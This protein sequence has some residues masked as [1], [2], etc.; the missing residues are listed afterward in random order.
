M[1]AILAKATRFP[2]RYFYNVVIA[3]HLVIEI[4]IEDR[5]VFLDAC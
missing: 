4:G 3:I 5:R 1:G 2:Y